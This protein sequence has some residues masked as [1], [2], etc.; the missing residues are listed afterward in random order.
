VVWP[1][2][3]AGLRRKD[4]SFVIMGKLA[5]QPLKFFDLRPHA[6]PTHDG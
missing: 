3:I 5:K 1:V 6:F 4:N 2:Q